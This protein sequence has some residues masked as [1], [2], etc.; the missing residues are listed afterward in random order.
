M[1]ALFLKTAKIKGNYDALP[2]A[3]LYTVKQVICF[4]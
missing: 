3:K 2:P 1:E 4:G